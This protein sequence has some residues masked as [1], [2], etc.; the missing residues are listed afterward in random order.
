M[1]FTSLF[2]GFSF[3]LVANFSHA[4]K[5]VDERAQ[6]RDNFPKLE[7]VLTYLNESLVT[8][9][10]NCNYGV[11]KKK[12]GYF[13]TL[14]DFNT[15]IVTEVPIWKAS[16]GNFVSYDI[17][18]RVDPTKKRSL[19]NSDLV[20]LYQHKD[21]YDFMLF[22]GYEEWSNDAIDLLARYNKFLSVEDLEI[23]ARAHSDLAIQAI[24]D[25]YITRLYK[26]IAKVDLDLF[27]DEADK[28]MALWKVIKKRYPNYT[29]LRIKNID[30]KIGNE[31]MHYYNMLVSMKEDK[32][33]ERFL[34]NA[35]YTSG[36]IESAKN[37]LY[38]CAKDGFLFTEG[39]SDTF[40]L[41]YVQKK[42]NYRSDVIV[43]NV[44]LLGT[45]WYLQMSHDRHGYSSVFNQ[46]NYQKLLEKGLYCDRDTT[47]VPY[48][49]WLTKKLS[50]KDTTNLQYSLAPQS[51]IIPFQGSNLE[52]NFRGDN[53]NHSTLA[54]LDIIASNSDRQFN[55]VG[56]YQ[57]Y[58]M[59]LEDNY[60]DRGKSYSISGLELK[61]KSDKESVSQ[62]ENL[63]F[64]MDASYLKSLSGMDFSELSILCYGISSLGRE[65][66][67]DR[68]RLT[69]KLVKQLEWKSIV[70]EE[71]YELLEIL[72][73]FYDSEAP[74]QSTSLKKSLEPK[75]VDR[76]AEISAVNKNFD[77][78]IAVLEN[79]FS[80]YAG[81]Q[82]QWVQ[83]E[84]VNVAKADRMLLREMKV[85]IDQLYE[86]PIVEKREWTRLKIETIK[87]A[88]ELLD[89]T[90]L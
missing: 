49:Q 73:S 4:K 13:L 59:G 53:L 8:E 5:L 2:L 18:D 67:V 61:S 31:Y 26:R 28:T 36:Q 38:G 34:T 54:V 41:W 50:E 80:I 83:Y 81:T 57:L 23:L 15:K 12:E 11:A 48:S 22:Y 1:K 88:L 66:E 89:L 77:E 17:S 37:L 21:R 82:V 16:E 65:F 43:L 68:Q 76:I 85:K 52:I 45:P 29:P 70:E 47:L 46:T 3:L 87:E 9:C 69:D 40:P 27:V 86:N 72:N 6:I 51:L 78:D 79:L 44:S 56:L 58:T 25:G 39:D 32:T 71:N 7:E 74:A 64:Y 75:A 35:W 84:E 30:L 19:E 63:V 62:L 42:L 10:Y 14:S 33:A 24:G 20:Q 55:F 90:Q 60:L